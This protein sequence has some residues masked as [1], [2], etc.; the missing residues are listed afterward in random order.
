[1]ILV[2]RRSSSTSRFSGA[3]RSRRGELRGTGAERSDGEEEDERERGAVG[4]TNFY[5]NHLVDLA[6]NGHTADGS[7]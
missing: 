6:V 7:R 2:T 4:H 1:M 3:K 5:Q